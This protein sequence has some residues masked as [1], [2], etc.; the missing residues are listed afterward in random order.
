MLLIFPL[1]VHP[2]IA[3]GIPHNALHYQPSSAHKAALCARISALIA[4]LSVG[5]ADD[6]STA[7]VILQSLAVCFQRYASI[8]PSINPEDNF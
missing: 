7:K 5:M 4:Q 3:L 2:L 6:H 1:H 8:A